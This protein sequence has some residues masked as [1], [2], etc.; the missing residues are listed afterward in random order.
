M[1]P[2]A[3]VSEA[4]PP[5]RP[6]PTYVDA[7][8]SDYY[9]EDWEEVDLMP[10]FDVMVSVYDGGYHC[11]I[12]GIGRWAIDIP[13]RV[14]PSIIQ[15]YLRWVL[16]ERTHYWYRNYYADARHREGELRN[17]LYL[18]RASGNTNLLMQTQRRLD[19]LAVRSDWAARRLGKLDKMGRTFEADQRK[20]SGKLPSGVDLKQVISD[21]FYSR[22][23]QQ[24]AQKFQNKLKT[25]AEVETRLASLTGQGNGQPER[26]H[27]KRAQHG[28]A[29]GFGSRAISN[30]K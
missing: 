28:Q 25:S 7:Y 24:T 15:A 4:A 10:Y 5:P 16:W 3:V 22:Q 19:D 1:G 30:Q 26:P 18:A 13:Y 9:V 2:C 20:L 14:E 6:A 11:F 21:S 27:C 17:L 23:N 8:P 29:T 12:P